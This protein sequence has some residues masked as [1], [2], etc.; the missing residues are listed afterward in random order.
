MISEAQAGL[1][2][3][4]IREGK[5][6][7][8]LLLGGQR[9]TDSA[10][11]KGF[12]IEPTLFE[13]VELSSRLAQEEVFGPVISLIRFDDIDDAAKIANNTKYG[14]SAAIWTT[15]VNRAF[16]VARAIKA[17][18]VCVNMFGKIYSETESGGYKQSGFARQRGIEGL[19]T[20][21][22]TKNILLH[23]GG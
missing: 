21:T 17:G 23:L 7:A 2:M 8:S 4:H 1:V 13:N 9:L 14:L 5:D 3:G 22:Q 18:V 16:K 10:H 20:F 15:N 19:H 6:V 12:F 11:S